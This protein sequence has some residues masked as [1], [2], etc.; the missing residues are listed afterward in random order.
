V[1]AGQHSQ[2]VRPEDL[3]CVMRMALARRCI[4]TIAFVPLV[5]TPRTWRLFILHKECPMAGKTTCPVTRQQFLKNAKPVEVIM[6]G[7]KMLAAVKE[8]STGSLGWNISNKMTIQVG[9]TPVTVQVGLNLTII[10]SKDL[11]KDAA[12][13]SNEPEA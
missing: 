1:Q 3:I 7:Q 5:A 4:R 8:F 9:D 13:P 10:G 2:A 6:D 12:T 11:P